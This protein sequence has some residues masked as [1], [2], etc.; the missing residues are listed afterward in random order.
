[1]FAKESSR[2]VLLRYLVDGTKAAGLKYSST[3]PTWKSLGN[4]ANG[5]RISCLDHVLPRGGGGC[6]QGA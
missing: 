3:P 6:R 4:F 2:Q 1:M 5:H